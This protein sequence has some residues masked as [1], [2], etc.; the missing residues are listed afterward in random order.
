MDFGPR[1]LSANLGCAAGQDNDDL[2]AVVW[3][4]A[5]WRA[6]HRPRTERIAAERVDGADGAV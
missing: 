1:R 4:P 5:D 2:F 3:N 6:P